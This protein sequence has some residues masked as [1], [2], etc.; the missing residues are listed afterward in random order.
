MSQGSTADGIENNESARR[1]RA[2]IVEL[3][4]DDGYTH[5]EEEI[6]GR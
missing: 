2:L 1:M 6:T 5:T 4:L 3:P